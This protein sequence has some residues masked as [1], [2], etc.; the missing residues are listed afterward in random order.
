MFATINGL[1]VPPPFGSNA[2]TI[3]INVD[4]D[5]IRSLGISEDEMI[6]VLSKSNVMAPS[7]YLRIGNTMFV[8]TMNSLEKTVK[9]F[10]DMPVSLKNG[11]VIFV[12]DFAMV[13]DGAT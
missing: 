10:N 13:K 1:S 8:T 5:K 6:K 9:E 3:L 7:G 2:R 4:P 11:Q 12:R